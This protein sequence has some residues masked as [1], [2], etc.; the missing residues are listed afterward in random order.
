MEAGDTECLTGD[1][2]GMMGV[3]G[4]GERKV[5]SRGIVH[6]VFRKRLSASALACLVMDV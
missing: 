2:L 4:S 5:A 6:S 1:W 3:T